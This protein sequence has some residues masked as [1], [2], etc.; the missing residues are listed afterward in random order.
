MPD[1]VQF[2]TVAAGLLGAG[3][4]VYPY[5]I[6]ELTCFLLRL[7]HQLQISRESGF[8]ISI[9]DILHGHYVIDYM[10]VPPKKL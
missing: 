3:V 8:S 2:C 4:C 6:M 7:A 1:R 9:L 10:C 5:E